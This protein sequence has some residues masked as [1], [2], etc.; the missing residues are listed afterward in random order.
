MWAVGKGEGE[1]VLYLKRI[2]VKAELDAVIPIVTL[3]T[4]WAFG[5]MMMTTTMMTTKYSSDAQ[6]RVN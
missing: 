1:L 6:T 2:K 3:R 5:M 4:R